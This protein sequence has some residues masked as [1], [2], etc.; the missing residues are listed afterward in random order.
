MFPASLLTTLTLL[1]ALAVSANPVVI[2]NSPITLPISR[3]VNTTSIHNLLR[4]DLSRAKALRARGEARAA[5]TFHVDAVINE[6]VDNQ[7][8]TYVASV[9]VGSPAST[10]KFVLA[11]EYTIILTAGYS[12][13]LLDQLLIDTGRSG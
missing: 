4:H 3:R 7:A 10:C 5:G 11:E 12:Q 6:S 1:L 2:R 8:V 13:Y 9:G